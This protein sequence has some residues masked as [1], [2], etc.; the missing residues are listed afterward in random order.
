VA[1]TG[2]MSCIGYKPCYNWWAS[3]NNDYCI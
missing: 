3:V 1:F 2:K